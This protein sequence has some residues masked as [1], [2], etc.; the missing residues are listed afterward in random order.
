MATLTPARRPPAWA[1][2]AALVS[3]VLGLVGNTFLLGFFALTHPYYSDPTWGWLGVAN[4]VIIVGQFAALVPV[5]YAVDRLLPPNRLTS[6]CTALAMV[7]TAGIAVA[8]AAL[9]A[10]LVTYDVQVW[11]VIGFTVPLYGWLLVA[12]SVGHRTQTL[13]RSLT[14][15]GLVLGVCW[16]AA[17]VLVIAGIVIGGVDFAFGVYGLPGAAL[18][19]PG[20]VLG[21][22]SWLALPWW[23]LVLAATALR[24]QRPGAEPLAQ[25]DE[26]GAPL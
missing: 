4:D 1:R 18:V 7:T 5:V 6:A 15:L 23:P 20:L 9:V 8:S 3:G 26:L 22:L 24:G 2:A 12:D 11:F 21:L 13:P 17:A 14:R 19:V 10:G 16:P 25:H